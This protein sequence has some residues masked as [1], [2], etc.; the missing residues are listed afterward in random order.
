[1]FGKKKEAI[2]SSPVSAGS[3]RRESRTVPARPYFVKSRKQLG[4]S[5]GCFL[6]KRG[7]N[8]AG[9]KG[10][11]RTAFTGS[12]IVGDAPIGK[13]SKAVSPIS[14]FISD[15]K[16]FGCLLLDNREQYLKSIVD[17]K[18]PVL[19][20]Y[21][22]KELPLFLEHCRKCLYDQQM[23][24]RAMYR[25]NPDDKLIS[26]N[27]EYPRRVAYVMKQLQKGFIYPIAECHQVPE[28]KDNK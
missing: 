22:K 8:G 14:T 5:D 12:L 7:L 13:L 18:A 6:T 3:L 4:V 10:S 27:Y 16:S 15:S 19:I 1:M 28:K 17:S 20:N 21:I 23:W 2:T 26:G 25:I 9:R 24:T 11:T